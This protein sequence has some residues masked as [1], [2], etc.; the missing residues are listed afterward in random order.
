L[1]AGNMAVGISSKGG[2]MVRMDPGDGEQALARPH[3]REFEMG[4]RRMSGW[5]IVDPEGVRRKRE[6]AAWVRRGVEYART[7]EPKG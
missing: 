5:V 3:V 2:L 4:K 1:L 6:L 7:L